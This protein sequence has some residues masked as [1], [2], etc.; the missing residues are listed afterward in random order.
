[1]YIKFIISLNFQKEKK[2]IPHVSQNNLSLFLFH[3]YIT[4]FSLRLEPF[5]F[6][7]FHSSI[8]IKHIKQERIFFFWKVKTNR[9]NIAFNTTWYSHREHWLVLRNVIYVYTYI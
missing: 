2:L 5:I 1:M 7:F 9:Y 6:A 8:Y 3:V 4:R